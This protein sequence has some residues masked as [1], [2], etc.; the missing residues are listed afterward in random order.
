M[1]KA[2]ATTTAPLKGK[3]KAA[4]KAVKAAPV[5]K[6]T[7]VPVKKPVPAKK[8]A[9]KT[10]PAKKAT[11]SPMSAKKSPSKA[12][13]KTSE[14]TSAAPKGAALTAP[15]AK[16]MPTAADACVAA[17]LASGFALQRSDTVDKVAA[18]GY[19]DANGRAVLLTV[20]TDG[21]T[22]W[23]LV[24]AD[25]GS[26]CGG[27]DAETLKVALE[28][29][30]PKA[31]APPPLPHVIRAIEQLR[32][33]TKGTYAAHE[34]RGD[35]NYPV[36]LRILKSA[37]K[38][39]KVLVEQSGINAV[40]KTLYGLLDVP[41]A[42]IAAQ[43]TWFAAA[44]TKVL[45]ASRK[46]DR[47]HDKAEKALIEK[48]LR[49]TV[50][51][52]MVPGTILPP[53]TKHL[54]KKAQAEKDAADKLAIYQEAQIAA[55]CPERP[56]EQV[57]KPKKSTEKEDYQ[58]DLAVIDDGSEERAGAPLAGSTAYRAEDIWLMEHTMTGLVLLKL[59]K[60]NSQ[61]AICV[62]NNGNRVACGVVPIET[63]LKF[64]RI[65]DVDI[66]ESV[67]QLLKPA[68]PGVII[69]PVA[70][71]HLN[72]VLHCKELAAM[73]FAKK[74]SAKKSTDV[75]ETAKTKKFAAPEKASKKPIVAKKP[76][77][78]ETEATAKPSKA[79]KA[80]KETAEPSA[81][82]S[83]LFRLKNDSKATW[84]AFK[85]QKAELVQAFIDLSAV[86]AKA[87]GVTRG[88]LIDALP[89]IGPKNISFYLSTWQSGDAPIVEKLAAAE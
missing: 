69:T 5:K 73:T 82:K 88:A 32:V 79:K 33:A 56:A 87:A 60:S 49:R 9:P 68:I 63:L 55:M 89:N 24:A 45:A 8:T 72:A 39:D 21:D 76:V 52:R 16:A 28:R 30:A 6:A 15:V 53:P 34:L 2:K 65:E 22:T 4:S 1:T 64:K 66:L 36:R 47:E 85:G 41:P 11:V 17:I 84:S 13:K 83:S 25:G 81:R 18:Y 74:S 26:R 40:V 57:A 67:R 29:R 77:V 27:K 3:T 48:E 70:E 75:V 50:F 78:V 44:C 19:G 20:K 86:G 59:E 10:V 37:L 51:E 62:Y 31:E 54:G 7:A 46:A 38:T 14:K 58:A 23:T 71:R 12:A 35:D 43:R 61:G 42:S 80:A